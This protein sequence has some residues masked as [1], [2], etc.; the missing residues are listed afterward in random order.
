MFERLLIKANRGFL[1]H[2]SNL[3]S[4]F[5]RHTTVN[6]LIGFSVGSEEIGLNLPTAAVLYNAHWQILIH[7]QAQPYYTALPM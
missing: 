5:P 4:E 3:V 2:F 6:S 1:N 7:S